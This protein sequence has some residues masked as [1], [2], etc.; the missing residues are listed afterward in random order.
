MD[1]MWHIVETREQGDI[2]YCLRIISGCE[3]LP[4]AHADLSCTRVKSM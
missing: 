1:D 4:L 2:F 3:S